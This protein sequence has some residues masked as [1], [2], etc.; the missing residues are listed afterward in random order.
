MAD[1]EQRFRYAPAVKS[2]RTLLTD[3]YSL[4]SS[5]LFHV[6]LDITCAGYL[7]L[8]LNLAAWLI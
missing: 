1:E 5:S 8:L 4:L 2:S 6:S 7:F 3:L